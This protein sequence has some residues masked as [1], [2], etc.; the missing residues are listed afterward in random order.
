MNEQNKENR[1]NRGHKGD[2]DNM[3]KKAMDKVSDKVGDMK[4][5]MTK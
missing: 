2:N 4:D 3:I 1:S 5:R